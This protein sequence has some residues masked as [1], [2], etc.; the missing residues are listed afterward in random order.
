MP[1]VFYDSVNHGL[2]VLFVRY[3]YIQENI[4]A[5]ITDSVSTEGTYHRVLEIG[6]KF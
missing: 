4:V 5:H 2:G 6:S 1:V 3:I